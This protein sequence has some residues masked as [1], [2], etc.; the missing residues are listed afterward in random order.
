[1][2][3]AGIATAVALALPILIAAFAV[4]TPRWYPQ[5]DLAQIELRVRDVFSTQPP[6]I[7]LGGR[8][9]GINNTQGA[10]PGPLSFYLLAPIH[11]LL[12]DSSWA[13]QIAGAVWNAIVIA[14]TLWATSR[15]WGLRGVLLVGAALS[16]L[17]A[18]YG[19]ALLVYPWNPFMP[20]LFWVLFLVCTWG[21]LCGDLPLLPVAV[22]AGTLCAQ[23]HIPYVGL[24]GG[25]VL[26]MIVLARPPAPTGPRRRRRPPARP[27]MGGG[28]RGVRCVP[29][30]AGVDPAARRQPGQRVDHLGRRDPQA[31]SRD[32]LRRGLVAA[33]PPPRRHP[34]AR[35]G[36]RPGRPGWGRS[37]WRCGRRPRS[38]PCAGARPT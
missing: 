27:P 8:I 37:C 5:V 34:P 6:T 4:R 21:V 10:H 11:R 15:R 7:G 38:W 36:R 31:R 9:Y 20:V 16:F 19:T 23:T 14:A 33:A 26:V 12:G 22:F 35:G 13:M 30:G 24:V 32:R 2:R 28:Q 25:L 17:I 18:L 29:V 3:A 1:M